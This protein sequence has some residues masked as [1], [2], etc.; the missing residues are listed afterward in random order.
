MISEERREW[1]VVSSDR[2]I[3][4]YAWATGSVPIPSEEFLPFLEPAGAWPYK[5][6]ACPDVSYPGKEDDDEEGSGYRKGSARMP[7]K[8][9]KAIQRALGKL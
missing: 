1:I 2:E 6:G 5:A 3:A 4:A 8:K 9:E 7:S